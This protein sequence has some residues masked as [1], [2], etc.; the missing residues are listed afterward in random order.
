ML[1][2]QVRERV[3]EIAPNMATV[4][5]RVPSIVSDPF[6]LGLELA[7]RATLGGPSP[8][9]PVAS[10]LMT[11]NSRRGAGSCA[12]GRIRRVVWHSHRQLLYD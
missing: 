4:D 9:V 1:A 8:A 3:V 6:V 10:R 5:E 12:R 11:I 2:C 7:V